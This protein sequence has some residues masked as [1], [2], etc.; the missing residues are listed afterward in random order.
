MTVTRS[1]AEEYRR[2]AQECLAASRTVSTEEARTSLVAMAQV[3]KRLAD[4]QDQGT[5]PKCPR[6]RLRPNR[7]SPRSNSNSRSSPRTT[8]RRNSVLIRGNYVLDK[9]GRDHS[10][11]NR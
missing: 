8:T 3:W 9:Y 1:K 11:I 6:R 7:L 2:L 4:E 10:P 5:E